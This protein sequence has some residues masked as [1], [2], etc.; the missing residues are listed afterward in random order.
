MP[1][2]QHKF[3]FI[4][5]CITVFRLKKYVRIT[6]IHKN[7]IAYVKTTFSVSASLL[8]LFIRSNRIELYFSVPVRS[9]QWQR[10][11]GTAVWTRIME[12]DTDEQ[13]RNAGNQALGHWPRKQDWFLLELTAQHRAGLLRRAYV[14]LI[15]R[16]A[17]E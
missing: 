1:R 10:S 3:Q 8:F 2:F 14:M 15:K 13:K 12:T 17:N 11:Y 7:S 4:R 6:F 16:L 9:G 5:N